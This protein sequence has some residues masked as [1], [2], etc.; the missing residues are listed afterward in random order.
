MN[1]KRKNEFLKK[2]ARYTAFLKYLERRMKELE[3]E[4]KKF[5][6]TAIKAKKIN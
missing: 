1:S 2:D 6:E 3:S 5:R 4:E